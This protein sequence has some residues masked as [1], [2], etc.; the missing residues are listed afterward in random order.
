MTLDWLPSNVWRQWRAQRVHCTPGLG[1][2]RKGDDR[3]GNDNPPQGAVSVWVASDERK[4]HW[5]ALLPATT[6]FSEE[7]FVL[8]GAETAATRG[9]PPW[10]N[11]SLLKETTV[12]DR[13]DDEVMPSARRDDLE[14]VLGFEWRSDDAGPVPDPDGIGSVGRVDYEQDREQAGEEEG[15]VAVRGKEKGAWNERWGFRAWQGDAC[16]SVEAHG[17]SDG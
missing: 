16:E 6:E 7:K 13:S 3:R 10:A 9:E 1:G 5:D 14:T 4:P 8:A 2:R 11:A 17:D 12:D 15:P